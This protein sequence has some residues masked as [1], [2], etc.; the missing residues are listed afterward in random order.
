MPALIGMTFMTRVA[1]MAACASAPAG[2]AEKTF[3]SGPARV[4]LVELFTS[5]GCS[6]CPPAEKWLNN[7]RDTPGL[8]RDF[9]PVA[10]HVNY[11]DHL[12]WKD[13]LASKAFT[14]RQHAY[15]GA[16][17]ASS[18]YT[19]CFVRNGAE[20]RP[21][22]AAPEG[23]GDAHAGLLTLRWHADDHT[24]VVE[25]APPAQ[26]DVRTAGRMEFDVSVALLGGGI[27][28]DVRRGENSGRT[29]RHEFV[30]L[31]LATAALGA[32]KDGVRSARLTLPPRAE[33]KVEREALAAWVTRRGSLMPLQA[34]GGWLE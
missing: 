4:A 33:I 8:W 23:P 21:R 16:W 1:M 6:S 24:C 26:P 10:F 17:R 14:E 31:R 5:E 19:P 25:Y 27:E 18:V 12:G 28:N 20:W 13:A 2:A 7:L 29:L 32:F 30:A 3:A 22:G 9:V 34:A 15:A 11:W